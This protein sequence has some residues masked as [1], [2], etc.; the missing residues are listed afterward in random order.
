MAKF[1]AKTFNDKAFGKYVDIVPK[2]KKNEL[3]KSKA[4]QPNS[5]IKD[6]FKAQT[7]VVYAIIPMF[8][9]IDG[10]ALNYDGETDITATSTT[11][12]ER[13]V[14]VIG[15]SKAWV[16]KDFA[17]DVTGGAGFMSNVAR[18]VAEYWDEVDQDTLLAIL[19]GIFKMTGAN[20]L[21][22][23]N[24][25]T[26][27][28]SELDTGNVV[29]AATLNSAIQKASGDKKSKFT[30][31]IMHSTV[32]TNLENLKLLAYMTYTDSLGIERQLQLA[33]WNGRAVL[34]DDGMPVEEVPE[35]AED[36]GDGYFKYTTYVLGDGAFDHEDIGA[37]VP[38]AMVRDEKTAGGQTYLYSRQRKVFAPYGISFTKSSMAT[39][40]PTDAE[41]KNG[42]NWELVH[43]GGTGNGRK[44]IDHKAIPI[45]RIVSRG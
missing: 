41:L 24:G 45:A 16:E 44:Y 7:G 11:T 36:A 18:Q 38:Y 29:G 28:I 40:S 26:Y 23:V 15:R 5:Q 12:Y 35:S 21:K 32:A 14:V 9:R 34:I 8:G 22:F 39:K 3:I 25:H 1:D 33:T 19:E 2:L 6:A 42:A 17:E 10:D 20:N 31:A 43:D 27:D 4:L 37:E 13:G 30:I